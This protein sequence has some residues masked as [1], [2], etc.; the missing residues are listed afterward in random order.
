[1][2]ED[3]NLSQ[4]SDKKIKEEFDESVD[5]FAHWVDKRFKA[6]EEDD[7]LPAM[8]QRSYIHELIQELQKRNQQFEAKRLVSI[9]KEWQE[10]LIST[11]PENHTL[12]ITRDEPKSEWWWWVDQLRNLS[13]EDRSTL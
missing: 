11:N 2:G 1:M 7:L 3:Q 9:D 10:Y 12:E 5:E 8:T 6:S 4:L 13:E